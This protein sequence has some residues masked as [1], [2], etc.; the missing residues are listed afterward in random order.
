MNLRTKPSV[1]ALC[2][3]SVSF[4]GLL[5]VAVSVAVFV[6]SAG[7]AV[8]QIK[9]KDVVVATMTTTTDTSLL[10]V[11]TGGAASVLTGYGR[12]QHHSVALDPNDPRGVFGHG[13]WP[14]L[15]GP[16]GHYLLNG[17]NASLRGGGDGVVGVFGKTARCHVYKDQLLF[18]ISSVTTGLYTRPRLGGRA[19][20]LFRIP[21][22]FDVTV[23]RDVAYVTSWNATAS[24][25]A[26]YWV[27]L[28]AS[29]PTGG[30]LT[31]APTSGTIA[32]FKAIGTVGWEGNAVYV[33]I[34]D[35]NGKLWF[36]DP[37]KSAG[38]AFTVTFGQSRGMAEAIMTHADQRVGMV[39]ATAGA[40]YA[41]TNYNTGGS[42]FYTAPRGRAILDI[43]TLGGGAQT[44]GKGC[45][46][47]QGV[48]THDHGL[49]GWPYAGN[50]QFTLSMDN[51]PFNTNGALIIGA[52]N[53]TY[54]G[55]PLP[56]DL[57]VI[58]GTG[59]FLNAS[60]LLQLGVRTDGKGE[61]VLPAAI[62]ANQALVGVKL[63]TQWGL[64]EA[65]ANPAGLITS[66]GLALTVR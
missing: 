43:A 51:G 11:T 35:R 52:S 66:A 20:L 36:V 28:T 63:F 10:S 38:N 48:P 65:G 31:L 7:D 26:I 22:A 57:S 45:A 19:R 54:A 41:Q 3:G 37:T 5:A 2:R 32:P 61:V 56:I 62:P 53:T 18:T 1:T 9:P 59:C 25:S 13:G 6:A 17:L 60:I 21:D 46:G 12:G 49:N 16:V 24:T 30:R 50:T 29:T 4:S 44:Y 34:G 64:F 23:M 39:I 33:V 8:A 14:A 47:K 15:S 58:G 42:P 27:D 40:M 55:A